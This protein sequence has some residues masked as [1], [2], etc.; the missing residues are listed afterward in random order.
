MGGMFMARLNMDF[1]EG[2]EPDFGSVEVCW[3][4]EYTLLAADV[5]K[6]NTVLTRDACT[7][8]LASGNFKVVPGAVAIVLDE[9]AVWKY[10]SGTDTWYEVIP[11]DE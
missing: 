7:P 9:P 11:A 5:R 4:D 10:H 3:A 8:L 6:L 2:Q 1:K